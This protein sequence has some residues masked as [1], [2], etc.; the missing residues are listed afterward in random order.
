MTCDAHSNDIDGD[1]E[2]FELSPA[3]L[4]LFLSSTRVVLQSPTVIAA[5]LLLPTV[6]ASP[7]L[8]TVAA[9]PLLPTVAA[10]LLLPT[11]AASL[12][13]SQSLPSPRSSSKVMCPSTFHRSRHIVLSTAASLNTVASNVDWGPG[14]GDANGQ[15]RRNG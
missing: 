5:S 8:P 12:L 15:S 2:R 1:I 9:S 4:V 14:F 7:L 3:H 10:S 6:A 13:L 11:V